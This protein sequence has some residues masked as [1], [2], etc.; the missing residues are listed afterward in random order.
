MIRTGIKE[1]IEQERPAISQSAITAAGTLT[2]PDFVIRADSHRVGT[3]LYGRL[4]DKQVQ[5]WRTII[6]YDLHAIT[7]RFHHVVPLTAE[8]KTQLTP[9]EREEYD[10]AEDRIGEALAILLTRVL[11]KHPEFPKGYLRT[12]LD[13]W[14]ADKLEHDSIEDKEE[15]EARKERDNDPENPVVI[16]PPDAY[17]VKV[18]FKR[19]RNIGSG[20]GGQEITDEYGMTDRIQKNDPMR[21]GGDKGDEQSIVSDDDVFSHVV[22]AQVEDEINKFPARERRA[23]QLRLE[24]YTFDEIGTELG[25]T[26]Q[27]AGQI[28]MR[29]LQ[30]LAAR[31][32]KKTDNLQ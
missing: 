15:H 5:E 10:E 6:C 26:G 29:A 23:V 31:M 8:Y 18:R 20:A 4:T 3:R 14:W 17:N 27:R 21:K 22:D 28:V 12:C 32:G 30:T 7:G 2:G 25:L 9:K 11:P 1:V 19:L 24:G 13:R 16:L